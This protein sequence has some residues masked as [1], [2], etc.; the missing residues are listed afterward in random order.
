MKYDSLELEAA[1]A[2]L[3]VGWAEGA[4]PLY[5]RSIGKGRENGQPSMKMRGRS[6][7]PTQRLVDLDVM[8][9]P[10][11][12]GPRQNAKDGISLRHIREA[13]LRFWGIGWVCPPFAGRFLCDG[14]ENYSGSAL[15]DFETFG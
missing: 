6:A 2:A 14:L 1:N 9:G 11:F 3:P 12:S 8:R 13:V 4:A 15:D 10:V 7:G 5:L